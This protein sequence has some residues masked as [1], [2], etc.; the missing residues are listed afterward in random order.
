MAYPELGLLQEV[1]SGTDAG[2]SRS[3]RLKPNSRTT[4]GGMRETMENHV[5]RQVNSQGF[6]AEDLVPPQPTKFR[7]LTVVD[8]CTREALSI[9]PSTNFRAYQVIEELDRRARLRG[10]PRSIRVD[11]GPEFYGRLLDQWAY[12]SKIE[13]DF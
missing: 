7:I 10:E 8:C 11:N 12:L 3:Y 13:L 6:R 9:A 1:L 5:V 2:D 4:S